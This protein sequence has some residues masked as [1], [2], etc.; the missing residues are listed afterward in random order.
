MDSFEKAVQILRRHK[1]TQRSFAWS[2]LILGV[3]LIVLG[4]WSEHSTNERISETIKAFYDSPILAV[5]A[6]SSTP[7]SIVMARFNLFAGIWFTAVGGALFF[8][9]DA[10]TVVLLKLVDH[11]GLSGEP[12]E[13]P[14]RK[15]NA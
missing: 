13:N 7:A 8:R 5:A 6:I 15:P 12:N 1:R 10:K 3:I 11:L 14:N 2:F 9:K 4:A